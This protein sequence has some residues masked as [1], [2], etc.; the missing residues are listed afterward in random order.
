MLTKL[1]SIFKTKS[2][3]ANLN[4]LLPKNEC[5]FPNLDG[6]ISSDLLSSLSNNDW[7]ICQQAIE[8]GRESIIETVSLSGLRG[9]GGA[10]FSTGRKW[11]FMPK[12][13]NKPHYLVINGDEGEPGTS[14][15][16][17]IMLNEPHKL[18]EGALI[19]AYAIGAHKAYI[20]VRGEYRREIES[21]N[22]AIDEARKAGLLGPNAAG[23]GWNFDIVVHP[24]AGAYVCGEETAL[25]E[26]LEG[27][28]GRP[29]LKP[30]YPAQ[31]GLYGC[32]TTVNN[33]ETIAT[34]PHIMKGGSARTKIFTISGAVNRPVTVEERLGVKLST[35]IDHY[36]KGVSRGELLAVQ[37]GGASTPF[38]TAAEALDVVMDYEPLKDL[39]T[40][41]GTGGLIIYST[42]DD[43]LKYLVKHLKFYAH[44]SCGQ[45]GPCRNGV[46]R[47]LNILEKFEAKEATFEDFA[48][49]KNWVDT[50]PG[51]TVCAL[52]PAACGPLKSALEK[53]P[54]I[55]LKD[56]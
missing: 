4:N 47:M 14:K 56:Q 52:G 22:N 43:I 28:P 16:R 51:T 7:E 19:S 42:E 49:L 1:K 15:D 54:E 13:D 32:P 11:S 24:G 46:N 10:G 34:I 9:R 50:I 31:A 18:L 20:Y 44:E 21:L 3:S 36:A 25:L 26:S 29:R 45:C 35:L 48:E 38:L 2:K 30:P 5:I 6:K 41:M 23:T 39:G 12:N 53:F 17:Y 55:F 33:V 37:P 40:E 27:K 8:L